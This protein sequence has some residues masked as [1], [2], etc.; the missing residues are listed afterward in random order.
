MPTQVAEKFSIG[1]GRK[2]EH[3][4]LSEEDSVKHYQALGMPDDVA[5]FMTSLEVKTA[6]G[7]EHK[8]NDTVEQV[9]GR[10]P[11]T[12]DAWVQENKNVWS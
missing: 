5:K 3:V 12:F 10:K 7:G 8:M 1:L 2:V 4:K 11:Q 6:N 9:T